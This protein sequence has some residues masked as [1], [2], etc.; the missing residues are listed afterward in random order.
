MVAAVEADGG[1]LLTGSSNP[2]VTQPVTPAACHT[3]APREK[4]APW[5]EDT[6]LQAF[7][8]APWHKE[9]DGTA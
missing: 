6:S 5:E 7:V 4:A 1:G 3:D 2:A 8:T 9:T